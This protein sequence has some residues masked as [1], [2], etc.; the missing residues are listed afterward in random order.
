[1]NFVPETHSW[2]T[3]TDHPISSSPLPVVDLS[4]SNRMW[5]EGFTFAGTSVGEHA[6]KLWPDDPSQFCNVIED[7]D[8]EMK[9]LSMRL[10]QLMLLSLG[11]KDDCTTLIQDPN[12]LTGAVRLNSYPACPDP[13]R[14]MGMAAHSDSSLVTILYQNSTPGLQVLRPSNGS[15]PAMATATASTGSLIQHEEL[16]R[17][18]VG[19]RGEV[20]PL[21]DIV[22]GP[23][24]GPIYR[25]VTWP[26]YR[27]IKADLFQ[28]ALDSLKM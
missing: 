9:G 25:G 27:D 10:M 19:R 15:G 24:Q 13:D 18:L 7:Y 16:R 8:K 6:R 21:P 17:L 5:S 4:G 22:V 14:A 11:L 1:M 26:E 12:E 23:A 3:T 2:P 20:S 28:E